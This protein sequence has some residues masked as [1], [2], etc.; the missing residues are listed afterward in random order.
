M[1]GKS[2]GPA[3]ILLPSSQVNVN[4]GPPPNIWAVSVT[5]SPSHAVSLGDGRMLT[6]IPPPP[7]PTVVLEVFVQPEVSCT[8]TVKVSGRIVRELVGVLE[9]AASNT[10]ATGVQ[11]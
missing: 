4:G 8:V 3:M 2:P 10:S 6:I 7:S 9:A 1:L 5:T 11:L